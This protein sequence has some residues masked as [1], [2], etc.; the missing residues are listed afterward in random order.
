MKKFDRE[1]ATL[2][3]RVVEMGHLAQSMVEMAI[4]A[5]TD[6]D[7]VYKK[8]LAAEDK[9]DQMELDVDHECVRLLTVYSPV[10][11]NLRFVLSVSPVNHA[12]ERIGDQA[13]GLCHTID[14]A[15]KHLAAGGE[16]MP[17]LK[18]MGETVQAM[19][20]DA[21]L[22]FVGEDPVLA[23]KTLAQDD[24][25]DQMNDQIMR[26]VLGGAGRNDPGHPPRDVP[27]ALTQ[28]LFARSLERFGDQAT[29]VCEEVIYMVQGADVRHSHKHPPQPSSK[30]G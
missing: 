2:R 28:I 21:I 8:V 14:F 29:N 30:A 4:T 3:T 5:M 6:L 13:V 15:G 23:E 11:A 9:I 12:L 16:A 20:R 22:A 19:I 26:E 27:G 10:A 24:A 1:L 17:R 18:Q 25:V 7:S